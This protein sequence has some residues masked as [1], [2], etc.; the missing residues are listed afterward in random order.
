MAG[1][2]P[3][4]LSRVPVDP[5]QLAALQSAPAPQL[6]PDEFARSLVVD[7]S[8][9]GA[10]PQGT[11]QATTAD[12]LAPAPPPTYGAQARVGS[13]PE[14]VW[15][16]PGAAPSGAVAPPTQPTQPTLPPR[17][18]P[19][20]RAPASPFGGMAAK[21]GAQAAD[22]TARASEASTTADVAAE[23][24]A[25][26]VRRGAAAESQAGD[27]IAGIHEQVA[28][29][30][31]DWAAQDAIKA[32]AHQQGQARALA[33]LKRDNDKIAAFKVGDNR[34]AAAKGL[35]L[36]AIALGGIGQAFAARGGQQIQNA[37]LAAVEA[38]IERRLQMQRE[39]L[40]QMKGQRADKIQELSAARELYSDAREQDQFARALMLR[41]WEQSIEAAKARG[42]ASK[43][44]AAADETIA[45]LQLKRNDALAQLHD[46]RAQR[47]AAQET[48]AQI[49]QY[50]ER[51]QAAAAAAAA[52]YTAA[53]RALELGKL[54][55]DT[56]K[57]E[58]E[59]AKLRGEVSGGDPK[60]TADIGRQIGVLG[61][62]QRDVGIL[63]KVLGDN[64][65]DLPGAGFFGGRTPNWATSAQGLA[66]RSATMRLA[67]AMLRQ[68]SGAA[69]S[70][71][72]AEQFL[73]NRGIDF[74]GNE[75]DLR[76]AIRGLLVEYRD[77]LST[78]FAQNPEAAKM[79]EKNLR[80]FSPGARDSY[81][82]SLT[83]KGA[84]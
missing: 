60:A 2:L 76:A 70:P 72:E 58:A 66:L 45:A 28:A 1:P 19:G 42:L 55:A 44:L 51:R 50:Q 41:G 31:H 32:S 13:Q 10:T 62:V 35:G 9:H 21:A 11:S 78:I 65:N 18:A 47:F 40:A 7:G 59:A 83:R 48:G 22:A 52:P 25:D 57:T 69:I 5:A 80:Q 71:A 38:D 73:A 33:E 56:A 77:R 6:T 64:A 3:F 49:S 36:L 16:M 37:G 4:D 68:E 63:N 75:A 34:S 26:A 20:V 15:M 17:R 24:Y 54:S 30:Q 67:S 27:A 14:A 79:Y 84:R 81:A 23:T 29:A 46:E 61:S 82:Q 39:Q 43:Q 8:A 74:T 12:F 53:K